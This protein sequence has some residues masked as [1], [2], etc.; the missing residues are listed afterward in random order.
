MGHS[1]RGHKKSDTTERLSGSI[2][3][4]LQCAVTSSRTTNGL[5]GQL[6]G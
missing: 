1:P 6:S 4:M 2:A 5:P 3:R